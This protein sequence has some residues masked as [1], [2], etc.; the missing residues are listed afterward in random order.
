[1]VAVEA[2]RKDLLQHTKSEPICCL[3]PAALELARW[4]MSITRSWLAALVT[5]RPI[6]PPPCSIAAH[7]TRNCVVIEIS[8]YHATNPTS[9]NRHWLVSPSHQR[10]AKDCRNGTHPLLDRQP[11]D[12]E[13]TVMLTT[14]VRKA[15]KV[16]RFRAYSTLASGIVA[17]HIY[18]NGSAAFYPDALY[19]THYP[20]EQVGRLD[21]Y[22]VPCFLLA[23]IVRAGTLSRK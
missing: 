6:S 19:P 21:A 8:P 18:Q 12:L 16:E 2:A 20:S 3:P 15:E 22:S 7:V 1:M 9:K 14:T 23:S 5:A 13:T 4:T 17:R 10:L 11:E